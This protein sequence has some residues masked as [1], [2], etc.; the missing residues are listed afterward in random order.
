VSNAV[1]YTADESII[2][3]RIDDAG[4]RWKISFTDQGE[5]IPDKDKLAVFERFKRLHKDSVRGTGIGLAIVKRIID[6]HNEQVGV[7]DN[8]EGHGS[9]FWLTLKKA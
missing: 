4:D 2:K 9:V 8:P 1:K 3:I 7:V 5:G 6:L